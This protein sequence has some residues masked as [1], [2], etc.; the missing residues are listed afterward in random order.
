MR[1]RRFRGEGIE[2]RQRYCIGR[3]AY[4]IYRVLLAVWGCEKDI[5][6]Q[7]AVAVHG[8]DRNLY[9][10]RLPFVGARFTPKPGPWMK[11]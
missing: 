8:L 4:P 3:A 1:Q 7:L 9:S 10:I 11:C 2:L 5:G 6:N